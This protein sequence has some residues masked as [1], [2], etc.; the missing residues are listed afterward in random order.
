MINCKD[1]SQNLFHEYKQ[2]IYILWAFNLS[3]GTLVKK[4][5]LKKSKFYIEEIV[6]YI[7]GYC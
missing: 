1:L 7:F 4:I 3:L 6:F 5:K 2:K